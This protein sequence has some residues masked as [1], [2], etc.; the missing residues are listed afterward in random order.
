MA[1]I[2]NNHFSDIYLGRSEEAEELFKDICPE[3]VIKIEEVPL[4]SQDVKFNSNKR[5]S[6]RIDIEENFSKRKCLPICST[7]FGVSE[8]QLLNED[9]DIEI[10]IDSNNHLGDQ[11]SFD[12]IDQKWQIDKCLALNLRLVK[13]HNFSCG[14]RQPN[15]D[16]KL[17][18]AD[19]NCFY[20][21]I[22]WILTGCEEQHVQIRSL[23]V[24]HMKS[25][26]SILQEKAFLMY[27]NIHK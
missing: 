23:I 21:C 1:A 24:K 5:R 13:K 19:G 12:P 7:G 18:Q 6:D 4:H 17:I 8:S 25:I 16:I 20:R 9:S 14:V 10:S 27:E 15:F 11:K 2:E 26:D 22:S 3:V